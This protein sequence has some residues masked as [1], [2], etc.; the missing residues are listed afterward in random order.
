MFTTCVVPS[1]ELRDRDIGSQI[2]IFFDL[3]GLSKFGDTAALGRIANH[4][5]AIGFDF[6]KQKIGRID[7]GE[8]GKAIAA[9]AV[10]LHRFDHLALAQKIGNKPVDGKESY[11]CI[12]DESF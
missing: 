4:V 5:R 9:R 11:A 6:V 7:G 8:K 2:E 1:S 10:N 12:R 3:K